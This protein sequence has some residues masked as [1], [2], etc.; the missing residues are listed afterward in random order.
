MNLAWM[1]L[2]LSA[3]GGL[4]LGSFANVVIY[5][6]PL[7]KSIVKPRSTCVSCGKPVLWH[8]NIPVL[9]YLVLGGKCRF[10][11][12]AISPRYPLVEFLTAFLFAAVYWK[13]GLSIE[14]V[15]YMSLMFV[16][17]ITTFVDLDHLIIPQSFI[18]AGLVMAV[19]G[20][21]AFWDSRWISSL[22]GAAIISGFLFL[23]GL[24]GKALFHKESMGS[25]DVLLGIVIGLFLGWKLSLMML[26]LTF[27]SAAVILLILMA[28]KKVQT[29][30]Q[31]PFGPFMAVGALFSL[32][33]G[34]TLIE[35]YMTYVWI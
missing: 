15:W 17:I 32:F 19:S 26:F 14:S 29:G 34:E 9:S 33:F 31:V 1:G 10:C 6:V 8:D 4:A 27:F 2:L 22:I 13:F 7:D 35:L 28:M 25:G 11:K 3:L 16:L 12:S 20:L 21:I 30:V 5:R 24:L 18:N 23:A